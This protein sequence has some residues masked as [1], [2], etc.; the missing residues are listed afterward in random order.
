MLLHRIFSYRVAQLIFAICL[1]LSSGLLPSEAFAQNNYQGVPITSIEVDGNTRIDDST[2]LLQI[3][4][5]IQSPLDTKTIEEDI[6]EIFRT[7]FFEQVVARVEK[8]PGELVLIFR[9]VEKPSIR[10]ITIKGNDEIS[11]DAIKEKLS[12]GT[13]KF[14]D[15]RKLAL[16]SAEIEK[17]YQSQGY[18][19]TKIELE[20]TPIKENQVDVAFSIEEGVEKVIR[21]VVFEGNKDFSDDDL[22][23]VIATQT[24]FWLTS[25][26]TGNGVVR[27]EAL[28]GDKQMLTRH[29]L[30]QGYV[31]FKVSE[32]VV[33]DYEDGLLVRYKVQEGDIFSFA[34][35]AARGTLLKEGEE[36]TL[37]DIKI[38]KG[39]VFNVEALR[40]DTFTISEKFTDIGYAFANVEPKTKI[41]REAKTVDVLFEIDK[42]DL[43]YVNRI[44]ISG[45]NKTYDNVVRRTLKIQ[46]RDLFSSSSIRRSQEL[47]QRLG[48]FE[49]VT[50]TPDPAPYPKEVD[51]SVAV[52][53]GQTGNFS[54]GAGI[55]SGDG[56][57]FTTRV[58]ENNLFG[59]GNSLAFDVNT[60]SRNENFVI[61]FN[62]P[63]VNDTQWSLGVDLLSVEREFDDFDREQRGGSL[64]VGYPLWFLGPEYLDDIRFSLGYE[65][66]F[67]DIS[68]IDKDAAQL[69]KDQAGESTSSSISPRLVRNTI[70]NPLDPSKGS[71]QVAKLEIAGLGGDQEFWQL[72]L[73]NT[74]YR[75]LWDSP[76]GS[77]VV[78]QRTRFGYGETFNNEDFP[79]YKRYFPGGINSVRGYESR[80]LGPTDSEGNQFGGSK[81][82]V[83][84]FELIFP[85]FTSVGL[86]GVTF[87]DIGQAFDDD[88]DLEIGELRKAWGWG[89]R[90]RSP[91]API[92]IEI[93]YPIDRE[94]GDKSVVTHFSF[95]SPL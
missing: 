41:N 34:E 18:Y 82:L 42:G 47:L 13:Q 11:D 8:N 84:N 20:I 23:D 80:E 66:L 16:G 7:G 53:E 72:N 28:A 31:D 40:E 4:S 6:K 43:I 95:G 32:P 49:E 70:D 3:S 64:T 2:V 69:V 12:I 50:I 79:L 63:R 55:S 71:R 5:E 17:Y 85:L 62:N 37:K 68:S 54:I 94:D 91:I 75:P 61:S 33:V 89:I 59:S 51:L 90:W 56:F 19:G 65:L 44:L 45:N 93:G 74:I 29:Y 15:R 57:I 52:R 87:F 24:Y 67:I 26:A 76:I 25:W 92:R 86:K 73:S 83:A 60:G 21:K 58:S 30:T 77:F 1:T 36:A 35:V 14:L 9:V 22:E 27:E 46:E 48:Y 10:E 38:K 81:Q 88:D 78:S 39:E